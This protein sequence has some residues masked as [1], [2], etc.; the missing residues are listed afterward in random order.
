[1]AFERVNPSDLGDP[2]G[3]NHGML[4]P[5]G[6]RVLFV[7]GQTARGPEGAIVYGGIVAQWERALQ[8]VLAVVRQA[9]GGPESIGRMTIYVTSRLDYLASRKRIGEV[10]HATMGRHY[11]AVTLVEVSGLVDENARVEI[12]ATAVI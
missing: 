7:A 4:G 1:M 11:P 2:T 6:G 3:F 10:W 9:G 5:A 12:E 8:N